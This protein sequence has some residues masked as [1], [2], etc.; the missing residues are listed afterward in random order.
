MDGL[1]LGASPAVSA[2]SGA[3][4]G[5]SAGAGAAVGSRPRSWRWKHFVNH[6]SQ[7]GSECS[8]VQVKGLGFLEADFV[9]DAAVGFNLSPVIV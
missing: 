8:E 5:A 9:L 6:A 1:E 3:A 2:A 4:A 7:C